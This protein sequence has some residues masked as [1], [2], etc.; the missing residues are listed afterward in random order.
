MPIPVLTVAQMREW[1]RA[2]W[3]AGKNEEAVMRAA[4]SA[5]A[6]QAVGMTRTDDCVLVLAG[7]GHNG[8]DAVFA[9]EQLNRPKTVIRVAASKLAIAEVREAFSKSP[10]LIIDGLFG[11]GL[12]RPLT[13]ECLELIRVI[14][15][16][17]SRILAVDVPSGLNAD[18]GLPMPDAIRA[19]VTVTLG[20]AKIGL[21]QPSSWPFV[22]RLEVA[23]EIGLVPCPFQTELNVVVDTDFANFPPPRAPSSHKG[24]FGH[25]ALIAGSLGYHGAAVL[26]SRGAQRA[27]PGLITLFT[28]PEVYVP[29]A[30]QCQAVMVRPCRPPITLPEKCTAMVVG[31]GLAGDDVADHLKQFVVDS[32]KNAAMPMLVDASA[33]PWLPRGNYRPDAI[34]VITPHPGEAARLLG[35][36]SDAIQGDRFA[37]ARALSRQYG[38]CWVVLKGHQTIIGRDTGPIF[39]N[40]SGNPYLAQG[41]TGDLLTGYLGGLLA[42]PSLQADVART[43]SFGVWQHGA[44][45]DELSSSQPGWVVEDLAQHPR[46]CRRLN[47][48]R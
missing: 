12:N 29:V 26:A 19:T 43:I 46:P 21:L 9:A 20:A 4:G 7:A 2:S 1:E 28:S 37:A 31:P 48:T 15:E 34:R 18:T 33:L 44:A 17:R 45:A 22:G 42:Q 10:A 14:N 35:T 3:A 47:H 40:T 25:V 30:S 8:D 24:A 13:S 5:L 11:I 16:S 39:I 41:G 6:R 36:T 23:R 38:G 27:Q 32:W